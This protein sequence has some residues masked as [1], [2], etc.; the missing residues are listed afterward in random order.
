MERPF[1][2]Q[3]EEAE[4]EEGHSFP[5]FVGWR[6][7][8][9]YK[10]LVCVYSLTQRSFDVERDVILRGWFKIKLGC[11]V[12]SFIYLGWFPTAAAEERG[13]GVRQPPS[14]HAMYRSKLETLHIKYLSI[15]SIDRMPNFYQFIQFHKLCAPHQIV[16]FENLWSSLI[17][18]PALLSLLEAANHSCGKRPC[19]HWRALLEDVPDNGLGLGLLWKTEGVNT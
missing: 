19:C 3:D 11:L 15:W 16:I 17:N 1:W 5:L 10:L 13:S 4:D 9:C 12:F 18:H 8:W 7:G 6:S 14:T 2:I